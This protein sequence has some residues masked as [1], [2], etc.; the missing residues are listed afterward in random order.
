MTQGQLQNLMTSLLGQIQSG[1]SRGTRNNAAVDYTVPPEFVPNTNPPQVD[2]DGRKFKEGQDEKV[3]RTQW[4]DLMENVL[5]LENADVHALRDKGIKFPWDFAKLD[6]ETMDA[7]LSNLKKL[8]QPLKAHSQKMVKSFRDFSEFLT[9]CGYSIRG[10]YFTKDTIVCCSVQ[11]QALKDSKD[12]K[13]S[14]SKLAKL[15]DNTDPLAWIESS[16]KTFKQLVGTDYLP[17][18]YVIC[19]EVKVGKGS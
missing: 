12:S 2:P 6:P 15:L 16:Y 11:Y 1:G 5:E 19:K 4:K 8:G 17:L 9:K 3:T 14:P 7:L 18:G 13:D 10:R